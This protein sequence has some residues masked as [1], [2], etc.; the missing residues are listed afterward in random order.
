MH[1]ILVTVGSAGDVHPFMGDGVGVEGA[2]DI[3]VTLN[4]EREV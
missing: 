4:Y 2:G 3:G 1:V